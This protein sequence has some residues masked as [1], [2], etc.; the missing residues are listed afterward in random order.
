M[1][2]SKPVEAVVIG[3][4]KMARSHFR[5]ILQ[6]Q[7]TTH[8][9]VVCE[10]SPEAYGATAEMFKASGLEPPPNQ[11]DLGQLLAEYAGRLDA[12]FIITPHV[13]HHDQTQMCLEAGLD[14]LLEK[15]MVMN[16]AEARSL[17]EVRDRT[18]KL[19]VVAFPGSLSPN[20]RRAVS[21]LRSGELGRILS[22]NATVWQAW[23]SATTGTW[24]QQFEIS[25]GGF[26]FD[27]GAHLLNTISDLAGEDFAEVAAWLDKL[28][29]PVDVQGT[30][31]GR[32][33]SG[34]LV[35]MFGCG[36]AIPSIGSDVRVFCTKA[37][38]RTGIW[39]ERLEIQREGRKQLRKINVPASQGVWEQFLAVRNGTMPNP[40]P[41]EVGLR[42][43]KLWDAIISSA[44]QAGKPVQCG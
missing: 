40:C 27:T 31:M 7:D 30:V 13:F 35:G 34:V 26:L 42:M 16:A 28:D 20:V 29:R 9:A 2:T 21:L 6:Q 24:R 38:L 44:A 5:H 15:P 12:A 8:I 17:I 37:T 41:P 33:R 39:G 43:A 1:P 3:T 23:G 11:P 14:V 25:G 19:L 10:P 4:G 36:E 22:I 18:G 32:L